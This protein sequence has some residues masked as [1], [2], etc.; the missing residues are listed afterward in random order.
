LPIKY[1]KAKT[2]ELNGLEQ[3]DLQHSS[4]RFD[5]TFGD[6]YN[7]GKERVIVICS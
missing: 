1:N 4:E 3:L 2:D 7:H 6:G 5:N